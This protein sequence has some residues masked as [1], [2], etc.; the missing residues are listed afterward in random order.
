MP[1]SQQTSRLRRFIGL[2]MIWP[3]RRAMV[4]V[5]IVENCIWSYSFKVRAVL[6]R[7]GAKAMLAVSKRMGKLEIFISS[8]WRPVLRKGVSGHGICIRGGSATL[9]SITV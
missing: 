6:L 3:A 2:A 4:K 5:N 7:V 1:D 8:S 9:P